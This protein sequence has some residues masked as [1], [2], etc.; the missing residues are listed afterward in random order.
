MLIARITRNA[1]WTMADAFPSWFSDGQMRCGVLAASVMGD[2]MAL[3]VHAVD[4]PPG[5]VQCPAYIFGP[6][7]AL[8]PGEV[9]G[10][11][12]R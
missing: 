4:G 6:C 1:P 5:R 11:V 3:A 7:I 9:G 2:C 12:L 8:G 10:G